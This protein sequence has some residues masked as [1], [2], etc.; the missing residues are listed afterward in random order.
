MS[1][2]RTVIAMATRS[3]GRPERS[4]L[5]LSHTQFAED[6]V[7]V[8]RNVFHNGENVDVLGISKGAITSYILVSAHPQQ[9]RKLV[10]IGEPWQYSKNVKYLET[11]QA[12]P[13]TTE[14]LQKQLPNL[15]ASRKAIAAKPELWEPLIRELEQM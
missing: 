4:T 11:D 12:D 7:A 14:K 9:F 8:I 15:V 13:L 5:P 1:Q 3:Y 2:R 10:A 6:A